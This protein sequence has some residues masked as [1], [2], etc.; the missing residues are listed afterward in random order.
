LTRRQAGP[1]L[2]QFHL[3]GAVGLNVYPTEKFKTSLVNITFRRPLDG[4][5]SAAALVPYILRRGTR[6]H[7][8][9]VSIARHLESLFG[10]SLD[11]DVLR[12]GEQ[13]ILSFRM[14]LVEDRY[15]FMGGRNL[16]GQGLSLLREIIHEPE[17]PAGLL[18][19][20]FFEQERSNLLRFVRGMIQDKGRY[21]FDRCVRLMC[22]GEPYARHEYGEAEEIEGLTVEAVTEAWKRTLDTAPIDVYVVGSTPPNR[23]RDQVG[24]ALE[25][26][27]NGAEV[28]EPPASVRRRAGRT[29]RDREYD[30][31]MQA[32]LVM[33]YRT[34]IGY[35]DRRS[36][37]LVVWNTVFGSGAYSRLFRKVREEHSLAYYCSSM[38]DQAKGVAFV[39]AG[40]N[41]SDAARV[42]RI[43]TRERRDLARNGPSSEELKAAKAHL[44]AKVLS[45]TDSATNL[46]GFMEE[47]R[48]TGEV[49]SLQELIRRISLV[50]RADVARAGATV[51]PDMVYLLA[52]EPS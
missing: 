52:G 51:R 13:Q 29:R 24:A 37:P 39:Q 33:G 46:A 22:I 10:A 19:S 7:P 1:N 30:D 11:V 18:R 38:V 20:D 25:G 14:D 48:T 50:K 12:F 9:M 43:V 15:L 27:R 45:I 8:D 32:R 17:L 6:H 35:G 21:A 40:V 49:R 4:D 28:V 31:V 34:E 36:V 44:T 41:E 47:R 26:F 42:E 2:R 23:V 3:P 5:T 16:L